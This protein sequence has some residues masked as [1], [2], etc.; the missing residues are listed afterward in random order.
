MKKKLKVISGAIFGIILI[1][2]GIYLLM[3]NGKTYLDLEVCTADY[4]PVCGIDG[5]TY[6]NE[7]TAGKVEIDYLGE[8]RERRICT[9]EEKLAEFCILDYT[10]VCGI[11][12]ITYGNGCGAC[13]AGVDS[14][15]EGE[16]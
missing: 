12:G 11:D 1:I 9:A 14:W 15:I 5:V 2:L 4:N 13:S 6:S 3:F 10:P 7:C 16:C 8:C